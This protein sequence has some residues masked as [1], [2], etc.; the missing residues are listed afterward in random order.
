MIDEGPLPVREAL[1]LAGQIAAG[2]EAAHE[3][4]MIHRDL[5]PA[6][7]RVTPDNAAKVLD[8]GLAKGA[9]DGD[10]PARRGGQG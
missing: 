2:L 7:V 3:A 6:N 5:K 4:G 9:P 1:V 10:R 8:F